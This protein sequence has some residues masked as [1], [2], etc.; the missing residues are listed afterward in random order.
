LTVFLDFLTAFLDIA[1]F[2][3]AEGDE[4]P[5]SLRFLNGSSSGCGLSRLSIDDG[6][7]QQKEQE[8]RKNQEKP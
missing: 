5:L 3:A 8:Q 7:I 2:L 1:N 4:I 6:K